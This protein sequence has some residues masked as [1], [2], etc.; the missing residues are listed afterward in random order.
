MLK[1]LARE[2]GIQMGFSDAG[3]HLRNMAFYNMGLRLLRHV[4]DAE[5]AGTPF[6]TI[7]HAVHRLTGELADWYRLDAGHLRIGDRADLVIIDPER[8]DA[9]LDDYAE[10]PV[11]QYGGLSRMVNRNDDTVTRGVRR[12]PC[13]VPRRR[14]DRRVGHPAH[15]QLPAG[16]AQ[17]RRAPTIKRRSWPVSVEDT[18]RGMW[19]ALSARDWDALK[20]FLS[21]DCI[22]LD[23][24]VG[25]AAAARGPGRHRQAPQDRPRAV[26]VLRELRRPDARQRCRRRCTS[27]TRNGTGPQANPRS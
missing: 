12:R 24:P 26:G 3:A 9:S 13:G 5:R 8:L 25:P 2:P 10:D 4:R 16:R 15:R 23:V 27:T 11:E 6:M 21:D 22:Y 17:V 1:K 19:K 18:V 20:A 14:G 7:E